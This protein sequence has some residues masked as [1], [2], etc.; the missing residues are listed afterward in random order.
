MFK[1][2]T[3]WQALVLGATL[4]GCAPPPD[5]EPSVDLVEGD[6]T[7]GGVY[8]L[9]A[10]NSG[11]CVDVT[12]NVTT[13]GAL[14]EQ[15]D[16]N[17]QK[18]QQFKFTA[19]ST[20][21]YEVRPM[22]GTTQCVDVYQSSTA[23][24]GV[25]DQ[26]SCNGHTSQRWKVLSTSTSGQFQLQA[27]NSGKC[28]EVTGGSTTRGAKLQQNTCASTKTY[29]R[30]TFSTVSSGGG[31]GGSGGST[32]SGG[33]GGT[34]GS[35]GSLVWRKANLTYFTSYPDPNSEE[36]IKY[37]GCMWAGQF[38]FVSG[39]QSKTWVESHNIAAV[40]E[41]DAAKYALKTLRL[42]QGTHQIDVVVYDECADS[43]CSG[44]CTENASQNGYN[45]LIDIEENTAARFGTNDGTVDW[46]CLNC[47]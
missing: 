6:L 43:D 4:F 37:N 39:T 21:V 45:F 15:W 11:K 40:H 38:A 31:T 34:G 44:C 5:P 36:C 19:V 27:L 26:W 18:N 8:V 47:N 17:G 32:G 2:I 16:C 29:Q 12:G 25:I 23:N 24:G 30:F 46:A 42:K 41:K 10:V 3:R 28:A 20:G 13:S 14:I 35:T 9:K 22:N 7:S 1:A 33:S